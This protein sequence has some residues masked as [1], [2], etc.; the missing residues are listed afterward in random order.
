[1]MA[2]VLLWASCVEMCLMGASGVMSISLVHL[3]F[4][5][6]KAHSDMIIRSRR[7]A[8]WRIRPIGD[9]T[10]S[11]GRAMM[12][13]MSKLDGQGM[14]LRSQRYLAIFQIVVLWFASQLKM[15]CCIDSG[16][17]QW[18]QIPLSLRSLIFSQ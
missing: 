10:L 18:V 13:V 7:V 3:S 15:M 12:V 9:R 1:M 5:I 8:P 16:V 2:D 11:R 6:R 4:Q 17:S 14:L